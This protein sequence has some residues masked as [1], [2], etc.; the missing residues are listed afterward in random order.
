MKYVKAPSLHA[1]RDQ[2]PYLTCTPD[3]ESYNNCINK[4]QYIGGDGW[5]GGPEVGAIGPLGE[6][7]LNFVR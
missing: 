4:L 1:P 7:G 6:G 3:T 2:S 5:G